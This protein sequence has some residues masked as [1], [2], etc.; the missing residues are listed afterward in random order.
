MLVLKSYI[1]PAKN[2]SFSWR[3]PLGEKYHAEK[4]KEKS[5]M[6]SDSEVIEEGAISPSK[7][8]FILRPCAMPMGK[9]IKRG[10]QSGK[11]CLSTSHFSC[12]SIFLIQF[13][14][15]VIFYLQRKKSVF[16]IFLVTLTY[17][18]LYKYLVLFL[19]VFILFLFLILQG[20]ILHSTMFNVYL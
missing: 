13:L 2:A 17:C 11:Q 10:R 8:I 14:D 4:G 19:S 20:G 1:C 5:L 3:A 12:F 18:I 7:H 6:T 15:I 16:T 9:N